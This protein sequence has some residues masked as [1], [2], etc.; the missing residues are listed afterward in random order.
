MRD[1]GKTNFSVTP[2][3]AGSPKCLENTGFRP[4]SACFSLLHAGVGMTNY[5]PKDFC[6]DFNVT[7]S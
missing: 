6:R 5:I 7:S 1:L 3:Q 4:A 2:A